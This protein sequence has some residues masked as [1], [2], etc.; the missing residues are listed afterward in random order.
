MTTGLK[1]KKKGSDK[2]IGVK[3]VLS[4]LNELRQNIYSVKGK[5]IDDKPL[6]SNLPEKNLP[7]LDD[8]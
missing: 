3:A 8:E 4:N 1:L 2:V 5:L 7:K 6:I